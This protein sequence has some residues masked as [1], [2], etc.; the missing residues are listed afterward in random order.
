MSVPNDSIVILSTQETRIPG[1]V[2]QQYL[3]VDED[4]PGSKIVDRYGPP[5][6]P[7]DPAVHM[8]EHSMCLNS[9]DDGGGGG[10]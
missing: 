10:D 5:I 3:Y 1:Y 8:E 6:D 7:G 9:R 2:H 4:C